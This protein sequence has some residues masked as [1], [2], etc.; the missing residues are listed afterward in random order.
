MNPIYKKLLI[1]A[2]WSLGLGALAI[3]PVIHSDNGYVAGYVFFPILLLIGAAALLLFIG[4]LI[5]VTKPAG[6]FLLLFAFLLPVGFFA[7]GF[8]AKTFELGAYREQPMFHFPPPIANKVLFKKEATHDEIERLW[9]HIIGYPTGET[10]SWT[11]P[12]IE[13]AARTAA[14]NGHEVVTFSFRPEATEDQKSDIRARINSYPPVFHNFEDVPTATPAAST[15]PST[16][17]NVET[18][19]YVVIES[20][21]SN[22]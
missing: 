12:G 18:K 8:V 21:N 5:T 14:E 7:G 9:T 11:R 4:G 22:P 3:V 10:S 2:L 16:V 1:T 20:A 6:P 15:S 19:K 13:G 17:S